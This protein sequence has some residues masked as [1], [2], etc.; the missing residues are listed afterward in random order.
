MSCPSKSLE[1]W[2]SGTSRHSDLINR[3][4]AQLAVSDDIESFGALLVI[5]FLDL[6]STHDFVMFRDN[7]LAESTKTC[8]L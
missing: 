4:S 6:T 1:V 2:N 8:L 7:A 3:I 5:V